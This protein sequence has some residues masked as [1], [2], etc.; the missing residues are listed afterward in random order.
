MQQRALQFPAEITFD[1]D[2]SVLANPSSI[3]VR[4]GGGSG[5]RLLTL[6]SR[7]AGCR[8]CN[9]AILKGGEFVGDLRA[10]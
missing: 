6:Q 7:W 1:G 5:L 4:V 9:L 8:A 10:F 2:G 3:R